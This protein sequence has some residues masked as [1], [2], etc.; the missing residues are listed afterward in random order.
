MD[1]IANVTVAGQK[2]HPKILFVLNVNKH[3]IG[4]G[5]RKTNK[6]G[7]SYEIKFKSTF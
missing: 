4:L 2:S 7:N 5:L 1:G 6:G 3:K